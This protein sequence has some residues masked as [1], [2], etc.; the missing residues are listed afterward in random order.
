MFDYAW[1]ELVV[2]GVIVVIAIVQLGLR[3]RARK[4]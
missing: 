3:W 4:R 1:Q 2:V